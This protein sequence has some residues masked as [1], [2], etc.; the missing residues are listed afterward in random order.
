LRLSGPTGVIGFDNGAVLPT[1]RFQNVSDR[2]IE[3]VEIRETDWFGSHGY[4]IPC[5][6]NEGQVF[7]PWMSGAMVRDEYDLISLTASQ[8]EK[9]GFTYPRNRIWIV[10]VV[11]VTLSDG[12]IYDASDK[13]A[14]LEK[15]FDEFVDGLD[16]SSPHQWAAANEQKMRDFV[17]GLM[18]SSR[19]RK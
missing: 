17:S 4:D 2:N 3:S 16:R 5:T 11:K 8:A 6:V 19:Q 12:T 15:F 10:M 14:T 7:T 1:F 13:Y 9:Y 18:T